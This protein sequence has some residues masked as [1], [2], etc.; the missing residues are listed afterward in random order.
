MSD[1]HDLFG[2]AALVALLFTVLGCWFMHRRIRNWASLCLLLSVVA[3]LIWVPAVQLAEAFIIR[4]YDASSSKPTLNWLAV[5]IEI[6]LPCL[7]VLLASV[8]FCFAA[9][10]IPSQPKQ[11]A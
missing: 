3:L 8:G 9:R 2:L 10:S 4:S 6:F 1:P 5:A 11:Q 7:L